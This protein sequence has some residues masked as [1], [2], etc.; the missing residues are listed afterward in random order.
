M[1]IFSIDSDYFGRIPFFSIW[2]N[3]IFKE[4]DFFS[5]VE[6]GFLD[7]LVSVLVILG[8]IIVGFSKTKIEDENGRAIID[9]NA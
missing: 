6:N 9:S 1:Y 8:G 2:S 7:E 3:G 5:I 4:Q